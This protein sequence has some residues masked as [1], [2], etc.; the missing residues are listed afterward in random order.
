M[1]RSMRGSSVAGGD[2]AFKVHCSQCHG[3]PSPR[4]LAAE[5]WPPTLRRMLVRMER[6][7][8]MP[9][10]RMNAPSG[11][12]AK[13]ILGYLQA[14]SLRTVEPGSLPADDPAAALFS[15]TCSRCHALPDPAQHTGDEWP[16]VVERMRVNMRRMEVEGIT[17]AQARAILDLRQ[18]HAADPAGR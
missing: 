16:A 11:D 6:M 7:S 2:S 5:E 15:R 9:L 8:R 1:I 17:D 12:E 13:T 18:R 14:N 10:H 3:I 4:Q